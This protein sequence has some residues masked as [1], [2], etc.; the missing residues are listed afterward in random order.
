VNPHATDARNF[1][2]SEYTKEITVDFFFEKSKLTSAHDF[3]KRSGK[4]NLNLAK[5]KSGFAVT[6]S[7]GEQILNSKNCL[8]KSTLELPETFKDRHD[9]ISWLLNFKSTNIFIFSWNDQWTI[10]HRDEKGT[11]IEPFWLDY[12]SSCSSI[13]LSEEVKKYA[14]G[15]FKYFYEYL[16]LKTDSVVVQRTFDSGQVFL[17][18]KFLQ[19]DVAGFEE[20]FITQSNPFSFPKER[21]KAFPIVD[22]VNLAWNL[23]PCAEPKETPPCQDK[24]KNRKSKKDELSEELI[25]LRLQV[26]DL[27]GDLDKANR[28]KYFYEVEYDKMVRNFNMVMK[29]KVEKKTFE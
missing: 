22:F 8:L 27:E 20:L 25:S 18:E 15:L 11:R 4:G 2:L 24:T 9:L 12:Y 21:G 1:L 29:N 19:F 13:M 7:S 26:S 3:L 23:R 10:V 16:S 14:P 5:D 6:S 17:E 28:A